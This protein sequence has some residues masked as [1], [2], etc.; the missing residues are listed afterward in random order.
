MGWE[1]ARSEVEW[2][3]G[4]KTMVIHWHAKMVVGARKS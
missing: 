1:R 3:N 4:I 2:S